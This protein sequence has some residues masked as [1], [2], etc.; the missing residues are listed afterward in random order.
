MSREIAAVHNSARIIADFMNRGMTGDVHDYMGQNRGGPLR[1]TVIAPDGTVLL[2]NAA[3]ASLMENHSDREEIKAA[4]R[5]GTGEATRYSD[6]LRADTYYYAV[7]LENGNVLRLSKTMES[8][9]RIFMGSVPIVV[10]VTILV[11][12]LAHPLARRLTNRLVRPFENVVFDGDLSPAYDEVLPYLKEINR[13]RRELSKHAA[14]LKSRYNTI[15]IISDSMKEGLFMID[16]AGQV[17]IASRSASDIFHEDDMDKKN[18]LQICRDVEF[19]K[20]VKRCLSGIS[21][22]IIFEWNGKIYNVF[23][24]PVLDGEKVSGGVI[25]I[26]DISEKHAAEK[27]RREFSANVS[28]ELKTP[29]T[30]VSM[31]AEMIG[32]GMAEEEDI[33]IFAGKIHSQTSRVINIIDDI[34]KLSEFDENKVAAPHCDFD[35]YELAESVVEALQGKADEK[36]VSVKITGEHFHVTANRQMIDELL[37][38]LI[39]NAI[40]YNKEDGEVTITLD[41]EN[42]GFWKI[43]VSDTGIGI[44]KEN[45]SRIF[46]RFYRVDQ[47]RSKKTGGTGL[48]LSIVK[49]ITEYH[50]GKAVVTSVEGIG[51]VIDCSFTVNSVK[52]P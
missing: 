8:I 32:N 47:S 19:N 17:L 35:L 30:T 24:S 26:L 1:M 43:T 9:N 29:L 15:A 38:N 37:F 14:V 16:R 2:D 41:K 22:E 50:G 52:Q 10:A 23:F 49:H 28:H 44:P 51:T 3:T 36:R 6:T 31:L 21:D 34:I 12:L 25:L 46:E 13:Q 40:K 4:L 39:D 33:E 48:G 45:Q 27:Q 5:T 18:I 7:L 20:G 42:G 11:L